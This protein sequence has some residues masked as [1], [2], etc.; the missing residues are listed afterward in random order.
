MRFMDQEIFLEYPKVFAWAKRQNKLRTSPRGYVSWPDF[1]T[2]VVKGTQQVVSGEGKGLGVGEGHLYNA[3]GNSDIPPR[4]VSTE[5]LEAWLRTDVPTFTWNHPYVLPGYVL[6]LPFGHSLLSHS[7]MLAMAIA[8]LSMPGG[9]M[10]VTI[11]GRQNDQGQWTIG[12]GGE[13]FITPGRIDCLPGCESF[14]QLVAKLAVNSWY[15]H[16]FEPELIT[17]EESRTGGGG[18]GKQRQVRTPIP[19]TWIGRNF[20]IRRESSPAAGQETGIKVRPHW[21]S[22]H[23][24]TV[25]HGKGR[26]QERLQWYRPVYVNSDTSS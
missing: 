4:Y 2:A 6:F 16:A 7:G 25:R 19:P 21:R 14:D 12:P 22:G 8:V 20:K 26:E 1:V 11:G 18:F 9:L 5:L 23:W 10:A 17:Q 15:T 3:L 24:H 13:I